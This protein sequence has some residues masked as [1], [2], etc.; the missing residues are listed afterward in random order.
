M[1]NQDKTIKN[2][3]ECRE[4]GIEILPPDI[5]ESQADFSVVGGK[6]RFGL[7]AVKNVGM[8]A[9]ETVIEE[10]TVRG[11]FRD[12]LD[13]CRRVEGAKVN[14]RVLEGLIQC[15]VFDFTGIF[16]SALF[17]ALDEINRLC[18]VNH[19]PNQLSIFGSLDLKGGHAA[20][21]VDYPKVEEWDQREKL[22]R[23]KEALGFYITGHPLD[24]YRGEIKRS[25]SCSIQDLPSRKDKSQVKVAGVIENLRIKRTK[26]GDKMAILNMEDLT[27]STE[28]ILF[29]EVF[30]RCSVLLKSEDP[31]LI[32]GTVEI[33]DSSAKIMAQ[34]IVTLDSLRQKSIK[35]IELKLKE[36][37]ISKDFLEDLRDIVFRYPGE[38]RLLLKVGTAKGSEWTI[39]ANNRFNVHPCHQLIDEIEARTGNKVHEWI[40]GFSP[41]DGQWEIH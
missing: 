5:N 3:A 25:S 35:A 23:E 26:R 24:R 20:G 41:S 31:L 12:L 39:S 16:R 19:D 14:R 37:D 40:S 8:K 4:M 10:R 27:G 36:E 18:G 13:F 29:P 7:A 22:R 11:P 17:A 32:S 21:T 30:T 15:G 34:D 9:V 33:G 38:C 6:I 2:L 28:C 1:G